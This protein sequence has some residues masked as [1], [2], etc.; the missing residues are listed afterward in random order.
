MDSKLVYAVALVIGCWV[1]AAKGLMIN[2]THPVGA[3]TTT[4]SRDGCGQTKTCLEAPANCDPSGNSTCLFVSASAPSSR[5][6]W[7]F[8][9]DI[10]FEL[11]G[12]SENYIVLLLS[13]DNNLGTGDSGVVCAQYQNTSR[14]F[15][16]TYNN[17]SLTV[18]DFDGSQ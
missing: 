3:L 9:T 5:V 11:R 7:S 18:V 12:D 15:T 17:G 4:I 14:F 1:P 16:V 8:N 10:D 13:S 2:S 6:A